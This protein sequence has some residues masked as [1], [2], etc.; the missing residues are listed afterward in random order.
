MELKELKEKIRD[1][2][3]RARH[4]NRLRTA[5]LAEKKEIEN[6]YNIEYARQDWD[7][8]VGK[9]FKV[10]GF[11]EEEFFCHVIGRSEAGVSVE[12]FNVTDDKVSSMVVDDP[13]ED[14]GYRLWVEIS[15]Q[16]YQDKIK[17]LIPL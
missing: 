5:A 8:K 11:E 17:E 12:Y 2:D 15:E 1:R 7:K 16:E 14:C 13:S 6:E 9:C 10:N 3:A 4:L